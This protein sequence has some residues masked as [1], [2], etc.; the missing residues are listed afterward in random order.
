MISSIFYLSSSKVVVVVC[1]CLWLPFVYMGLIVFCLLSPCYAWRD[2]LQ[3]RCASGIYAFAFLH[4]FR[5]QIVPHVIRVFFFV[6]LCF[7]L[8]CCVLSRYQ[9]KHNGDLIRGTTL[10][11]CLWLIVCNKLAMMFLIY[12]SGLFWVYFIWS[13][14]HTSL[15]PRRARSWSLRTCRACRWARE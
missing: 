11:I 6:N 5:S 9:D 14:R 7:E 12:Y 13:T 4:V 3:C 1:R 15:P 2:W 10:F 8:C